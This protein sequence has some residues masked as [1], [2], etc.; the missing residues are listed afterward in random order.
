MVKKIFSIALFVCIIFRVGY[1]IYES[2]DKYAPNYWTRYDTLKGVFGE[3]QY[4]MKAWKFWIPDETVYSY[5]GGAY[6]KGANPIIV[7]STQPPLG[8]YLIA[9]SIAFTGNENSIIPVFYVLLLIGIYLLSLRVSKSTVISLVVVI[10]ASFEKMFSDQLFITPL[11][12]IFLITFLVYAVLAAAFGLEKR[13]PVFILVSYICFGAALMIKVWLIG[14]VFVLPVTLYILIRNGKYYPCI[15]GG[16]FIMLG[17][18]L[19][20]YTRMFMNGYTLLQ[21]LLVQKWLYWYQNGKRSGLFTIWPLI[22][23]N[24]WYVWWG[25]VPVIG[26]ANWSVSWPVSIGIGVIASIRTLLQSIKK[27]QPSLYLVAVCIIAYALFMSMGQ[28][29]ARYLL[30]LLPFCY[31]MGGWLLTRIL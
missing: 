25:N 23:M 7:E 18:T 1:L 15:I 28:A 22:F 12:D 31:V 26:D 24:K 4:S 19:I 10:L 11:L 20:S 14:M 5:A 13:K 21:V 29:S 9:L 3:S 27:S 6:L 2:R 8:K 30:A 17:I 16:F